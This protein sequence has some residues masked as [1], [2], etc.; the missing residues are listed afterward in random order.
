MG[1][2]MIAV[3]VLATYFGVP[4]A[5]AVMTVPIIVT[6]SW[7][8]WRF[9]GFRDGTRFL[10]IYLAASVPGVAAGTWL[11]VALPERHLSVGLGLMV[12]TYIG[13]RLARPDL[14]LGE[15]AAERLAPGAGFLAGGLQGAS[16]VSAPITLTFVHA[17]RLPRETYIFAVSTMFLVATLVQVPA[18]ALSG[19]MTGRVFLESVA[20]LVPVLLMMPA[21]AAL[22]RR[23]NRES[24]DRLLAA[25]L[26]AL[27]LSLLWKGLG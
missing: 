9:R 13:L 11:L 19:V 15:K 25:L 5:A 22:G 24:F 21:G 8:L 3:P 7:Q 27:G 6:N 14:V 2:P 4:H 17:L 12:L 10:P 16:G 18:L 23:M 20:A 26:L 1:L